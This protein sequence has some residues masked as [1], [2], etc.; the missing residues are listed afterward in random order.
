MDII[1]QLRTLE[2]MEVRGLTDTAA[3]T[4]MFLW[5]GCEP[6]HPPLELPFLIF[7]CIL[8]TR[9]ANQLFHYYLA[10]V[11]RKEAFKIRRSTP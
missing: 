9:D 7:L 2:V 1:F 10:T 6:T 3:Q 11:F 5:N 4:P 8:S